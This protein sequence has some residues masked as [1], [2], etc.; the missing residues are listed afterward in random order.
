MHL[1]KIC[2]RALYSGE[3]NGAQN[4]N[5]F[6]FTEKTERERGGGGAGEGER[7]LVEILKTD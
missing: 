1:E 6:V 2:L 3:N 7:D 4:T 5:T